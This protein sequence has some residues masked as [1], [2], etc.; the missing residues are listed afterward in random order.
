MKKLFLTF[1]IFFSGL[2]V[3]SAENIEMQKGTE[4]LYFSDCRIQSIKSNNPNIIAAQ[5]I[6][7][8]NGEG[9][10][11]L[12]F[13]KKSGLANVRIVTDN[14]THDYSVT[15]KSN[16]VKKN[17]VFLELDIPGIVE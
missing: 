14:A 8:Y 16:N 4:Y 12:F 6:M 5:R 3:F 11:V 7:T 10:Q 9:N 2:S 15:I 17:D 1:V 13:A